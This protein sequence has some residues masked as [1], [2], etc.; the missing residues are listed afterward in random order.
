MSSG[1]KY[2]AAAYAVVL[3]ALLV[4]VAIIA[5]KL[6]RLDRETAELAAIAR[7]TAAERVADDG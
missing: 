2:V 6:V 7:R 5:A 3:L 1:E 4:W